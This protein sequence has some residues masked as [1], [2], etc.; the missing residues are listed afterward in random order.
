MPST[1]RAVAPSSRATARH[2]VVWE[3][4]WSIHRRGSTETRRAHGDRRLLV[5]S[6]GERK[7]HPSLPQLSNLSS[8]VAGDAESAARPAAAEA[9]HSPGVSVARDETRNCGETDRELLLRPEAEVVLGKAV[10]WCWPTADLCDSY[11]RRR[12]TRARGLT[13]ERSPPREEQRRFDRGFPT[14]CLRTTGVLERRD[15]GRPGCCY[16]PGAGVPISTGAARCSSSRSGC[17]GG[18]AERFRVPGGR[19]V[20]RRCRPYL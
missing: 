20:Q 1:S 4:T 5:P 15:V 12:L 6:H 19:T 14:S 11:N 3:L 2:L 18:T 10:R 17:N 13:V 7:S 9:R 16:R 8:G